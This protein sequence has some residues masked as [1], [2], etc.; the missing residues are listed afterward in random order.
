MYQN[1][2]IWNIINWEFRLQASEMW[3][4]IRYRV[5]I[6]QK[7]SSGVKSF[8]KIS[9]GISWPLKRTQHSFK[10]TGQHPRNNTAS[11]PR[12]PKPSETVLWG[13]H[14]SHLSDHH[15]CK[16]KLL[17][18]HFATGGWLGH[19]ECFME[20]VH[21]KHVCAIRTIQSGW[22]SSQNADISTLWVAIPV[23]VVKWHTQRVL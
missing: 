15:Y 22:V 10:K 11:H 9:F 14:I 5:K 19:E 21:I 1:I 18:P 20:T 4:V 2:Q 8:Q 23:C 6:S 7:N 3:C 16:H 17:C 13:A 12:R